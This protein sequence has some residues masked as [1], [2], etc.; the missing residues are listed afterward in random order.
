VLE[1]LYTSFPDIENELFKASGCAVFS[2]NNFLLSNQE[3]GLLPSYVGRGVVT[4][5]V[6][7]NETFM[8]V[9]GALAQFKAA[10]KH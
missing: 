2:Q 7:G 5:N 8:K 9:K 10:N 6:S 4:D 3:I 1:Q